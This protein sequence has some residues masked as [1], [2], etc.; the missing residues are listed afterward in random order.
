MIFVKFYLY[1]L[2]VFH[3][4]LLFFHFFLLVQIRRNE[5]EKKKKTLI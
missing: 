4:R 2:F 5:M 1:K 3:I